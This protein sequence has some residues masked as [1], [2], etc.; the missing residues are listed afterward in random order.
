MPSHPALLP[1]HP[2]LPGPMQ[3]AQPTGELAPVALAARGASGYR[4]ACR[5]GPGIHS[6]QCFPVLLAELLP[7]E[8]ESPLAPSSPASIAGQKLV[9]ECNG[10]ED[11]LCAHCESGHYQ[12]SWTKERH[13]APHDICEDSKCSLCSLAPVCGGCRGWCPPRLAHPVSHFI[14]APFAQMPASL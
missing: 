11:S 13:C 2:S 3:H 9:S 5:S 14:C 10:T 6:C 4:A 1:Q 7:G 12:Q 8:G